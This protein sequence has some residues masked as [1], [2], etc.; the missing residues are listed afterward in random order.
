MCHQGHYIV[1]NNLVNIFDNLGIIV[2]PQYMTFMSFIDQEKKQ[3]PYMSQY[4]SA[5]N[6]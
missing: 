1:W 6:V 4:R 5:L 2:A 3:L